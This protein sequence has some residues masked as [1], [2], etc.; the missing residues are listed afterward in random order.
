MTA[1]EFDNLDN[2]SKAQVIAE[3]GIFIDS[4]EYYNQRSRLYAI[5]EDFFEITS[6]PTTGKISNV[7]PV[8]GKDLDKFINRIKLDI[9]FI[10]ARCVQ[11]PLARIKAEEIKHFAIRELRMELKKKPVN[12]DRP[13][14]L[15]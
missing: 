4:I 15:H 6:D 10:P 9:W 7:G 13:I 8:Y 14:L 2:N 1:S 5:G 3:T 12:I 11:L